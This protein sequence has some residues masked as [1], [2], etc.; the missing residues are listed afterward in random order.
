MDPAMFDRQFTKREDEM[1]EISPR[2][3]LVTGCA[4]FIGST[5][6]ERLLA[7]GCEV[8]GLDG[9]TDYYAR[10]RKL[11]NLARLHDY[12]GFTLHRLDLACDSLAAH[13]E[14]IDAIFHLAGRPGVR[15]SFGVD[16]GGYVHDNVVGT[17]RLLEAASA[18]PLATVVYASSSSVYGTAERMPTD[19]GVALQPVSPYGI[20]KVATEALA[21]MYHRAHGLH[22]VG[23]RYFT[24]YGPRQRP[25]MAFSRFIG[26]AIDRRPITVFGT[27][28][29]TRDFTYVDDA[30]TATLLAAERGRAGRVY[31]VGGGA[32]V[33]LIDALHTIGDLVG[34]PLDIQH[35]PV[36]RGDAAA[37]CADGGLAFEELGFTP[38]TALATGLAGQ[39]D[40]ALGRQGAFALAA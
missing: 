35:R 11:E 17:Q 27:G 12:T 34:R 14:G 29:Q 18:A 39:V 24:V 25:D 2:R 19:E 22:V 26:A 10:E 8:V 23:L 16:F 36:A 38:S 6:C 15:T 33:R 40:F 31:N 21:D 5:L 3:V 20:T 1:F 9:M 32:P 28:A 13:V 30:V 37:T 4:G 7:Q